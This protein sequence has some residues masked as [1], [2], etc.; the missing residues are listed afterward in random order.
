MTAAP[1]LPPRVDKPWGYFQDLHENAGAVVKVI[2]VRPGELLSLQS[3]QFR[4]EHWFVMQGTAEVEI[5]GERKTLLAG[6]SLDIRVGARHRLA[7]LGAGPLHVLEIQHGP[8]LSELDI[9]RYKDRYGRALGGVGAGRE[10]GMEMPV[11]VCEI[12][13][14]H[15]GEFDTALEMVKIAA[16]FCKVDVV[17]FQKRHSRELLTPGEYDAPHPNPANSY[18]ATYG[19][20]REFLEFDIEQHKMLKAACEEWGVTYSTSVWEL[21][22]A[23]EVAGLAPRLVKVPSAVNTDLPLLS[24]LF[25]EVPGEIHV[26][27]G[28]TTAEERDRVVEIAA[29]HSREKDTVL[30]HCVSGYPVEFEDLFLGEVA[31]LKEAYGDTVKRIGFSG[32]HRGIAADIAALALGADYVERH[33]TLDRT[34]K[35]TDHAASLE[36]DGLRRLTRDLKAARKALRTKPTEILGVEEAQR[37]KL[38]RFHGMPA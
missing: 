14:N 18:G 26:S 1:N 13:C 34:W 17:K 16:Q 19:K 33:F 5:D 8:W 32:H 12:G 30:Y 25:G 28:M 37:K 4:A 22:S 15:R 2:A 21:T 3:H 20:H 27:L 7:N 23:R 24:Y 29:Q 38:K 31:T 11:V 6:E 36:P 9:I 35:G 10:I